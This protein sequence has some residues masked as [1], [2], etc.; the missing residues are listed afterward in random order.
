M[1]TRVYVAAAVAP[2]AGVAAACLGFVAT[3]SLVLGAVLPASGYPGTAAHWLGFY[4]LFGLPLAYFAE[5][6]AILAY[7]TVHEGVTPPLRTAVAGAAVVGGLLVFGVWAA[8]FGAK[9]GALLLPSGV[10]GG[11]VAGA[12]FWAVGVRGRRR[13]AV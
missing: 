13:G 7:R 5:L 6:A 9:F 4:L 12:V 3:G 1:T 2:L 8:I 10:V 11:A